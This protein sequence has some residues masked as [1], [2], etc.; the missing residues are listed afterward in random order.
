MTSNRPS[1]DT[2]TTRRGRS[3][4]A[5]LCQCSPASTSFML[6]ALRVLHVDP[7]HAPAGI[8]WIEERPS[9]TP[10]PPPSGHSGPRPPRTPKQPDQEHEEAA[11]RGATCVPAMSSNGTHTPKPR[12]FPRPAEAL[13]PNSPSC[14]SQPANISLTAPSRTDT[15]ATSST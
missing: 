6:A 1:Q 2:A 10:A 9:L 4:A 3:S 13:L 14:G 11:A 5:I 12:S 8:A 15:H 7:S